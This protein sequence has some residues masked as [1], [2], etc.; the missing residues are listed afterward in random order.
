MRCFSGLMVTLILLPM[1]LCFV[2]CGTAGAAP[3]ARRAPVDW[4]NPYIGTAG[5]GTEYGIMP[6]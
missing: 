2:V 4:V 6:Q 3:R 1:C 5:G